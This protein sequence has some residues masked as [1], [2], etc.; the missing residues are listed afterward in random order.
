MARTIQGALPEDGRVCMFCGQHLANRG[1]A[2]YDH[3]RSTP[4][5]K[6]AW[7]AWTERIDEDRKGGG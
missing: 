7:G 5:C 2:Y 3:L 1:E 4:G 6:D